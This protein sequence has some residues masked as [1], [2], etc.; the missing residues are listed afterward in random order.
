MSDPGRFQRELQVALASAD[1]AA[2]ILLERSGADR[3]REKARADLVTTVDE[4]SERAI[5]ASVRATFPDDA[6][7]AE[8]FSA[9]PR[10]S[11]RRWI[12][13]P[14]DGTVNFVHG[15]PFTCVSIGFA[16]DDG[17][18]VGVI[19][20][21]FLGERFH[22]VRGGGAFLNN[23][24]IRVSE[25]TD[26]AAT[27]LATGFPFKAGKGDPETY[28]QLVAEMVASTHGI[29]RAGAAALDLAYVAC[30]RLDGYFELGLAPWDI[31]AGLLLVVE[32]GGQVSG[33]RNDR[34]E[35]L[36]SG[37]VLAS[38]GRIH[39]WLR[40]ATGKYVPPL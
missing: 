40:G 25:V 32:A 37:R 27:L 16:D 5:E 14:V 29:R 39:D 36:E 21:P 18:A 15:H 31:A 30:G 9:S 20:A 10:N 23:R 22:A 3:V 28:F 38:N 17:V 34:S 11:G 13:D 35:A 1:T 12:V 4:A 19:D 8:E 6:F 2:K 26:P 7:V 24:P 33:W